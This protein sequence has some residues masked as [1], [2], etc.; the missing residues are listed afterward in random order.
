MQPRMNTSLTVKRH[1]DRLRFIQRLL[2]DYD[3]DRV[4]RVISPNETMVGDNYMWVGESAVDVI[5]NS[6]AASQ[7]WHVQTVLDL[8]CGHGRVLRHL[9]ELFPGARFDA[10]DLDEDGASFCANQFGASIVAA[11]AEL[12][13]TVFPH[14]YDVIWIGSLFTHVSEDRTAR[15]LAFLAQQLTEKGVIVATFHGRWSTRM[16]TLIP[17]TDDERWSKVANGFS[18]GGYGFV[19]YAPGHGHDFV[20]GSYGVSAVRPFR[21]ME[22]FEKIPDVRLFH[23]QEKAWGENQDVLAFGKPDWS[24]IPESWPTD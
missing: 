20:P 6:L 16:Q 1:S 11:K 14:K 4:S 24:A 13:E 22:I 10:C 12:A 8:P 7:L 2:D 9:V 15:W 23:Y 18:T 17:Y 19:D 5:I 21:L 3:P